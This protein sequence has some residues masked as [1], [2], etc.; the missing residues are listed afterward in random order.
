[1][2][3]IL[4]RER[5]E[6]VGPA[7]PRISVFIALNFVLEELLAGVAE[8]PDPD[9]E[10]DIQSVSCRSPDHP[11][12]VIE[13]IDSRHRFKIMIG[14]SAV[15]LGGASLLKLPEDAVP[16][17]FTAAGH[18][19]C[20]IRSPDRSFFPDAF[21]PAFDRQ[22]RLVQRHDFRAFEDRFV[23]HP[24]GQTLN[25]EGHFRFRIAKKKGGAIG[26]LFLPIEFKNERPFLPGGEGQLPHDRRGAGLSSEIGLEGH[27]RIDF[28]GS[29]GVVSDFRLKDSSAGKI[30]GVE[31]RSGEEFQREIVKGDLPVREGS[32]D[33]PVSEFQDFVIVIARFPNPDSQGA[34]R[35]RR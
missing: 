5:T 25:V 22:T 18:P 20:D 8:V 21:P 28:S 32:F 35:K 10:R 14:E 3:T 31:R 24:E 26:A 27:D 9:A 16:G 13:M 11:V 23:A 12:E 19:L 34:R 4:F 1:M 17:N 30:E 7:F 33:P 2:K 6:A 29:R 15:H